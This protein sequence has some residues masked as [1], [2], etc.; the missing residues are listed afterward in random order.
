MGQL[1]HTLILG[2]GNRSK[3]NGFLGL[4][5]LGALIGL[6]DLGQQIVAVVEGGDAPTTIL[7]QA[8]HDAA[9]VDDRVDRLQVFTAIGNRR[10]LSL[11]YSNFGIVCFAAP[12]CSLHSISHP[13][14]LKMFHV[15]KARK[16]PT[17]GSRLSLAAEW[18]GGSCSQLPPGAFSVQPSVA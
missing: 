1:D 3:L 7:D 12:Q 2:N 13:S 6:L 11:F 8:A 4:S 10:G 9:S 18:Q 17:V 16:R 14:L 15:E 5:D